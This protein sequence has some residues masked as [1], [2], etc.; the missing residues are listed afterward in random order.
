MAIRIPNLFTYA[1]LARRILVAI[2]LIPAS[3]FATTII[4]VRTADFIII[5]T[6]S[7]ATYIGAAGAPSVCKIYNTGQLYFAVAGL[8]GDARRNFSLKN[9]VA[10]SLSSS[11]SFDQQVTR[12][13]NA[14]S[15]SLVTELNHLQLEDPGVYAFAMHNSREVVSVV[16][17]QYQ[18]GVPHL[19]ARGFAWA[20]NPSPGIVI[21]RVTCP[22]DCPDGR[23]LVSLGQK[24]AA[25][26]FMR[27]N[28]G[29]D[30]DL[31]AL[32][33]KLVQLEIDESPGTV[34]PPINELRLDKDGATWLS[35]SEGCPVPVE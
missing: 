9:I 7:K 8:D 15:R 4:A 14:I 12:V 6:D 3:T 11:A 30:F 27:A 29:E 17:A 18:D 1:W 2:C 25:E 19:A 23:E 31:P 20:M 10:K 21:N 26:R 22:G 35:N 33:T 28:A 16:L 32:A 24:N 13:E 34:G 5:A